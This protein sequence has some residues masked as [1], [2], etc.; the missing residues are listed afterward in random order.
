M[1]MKLLRYPGTGKVLNLHLRTLLI[2][3]LSVKKRHTTVLLGAAKKRTEFR[4][5]LNSFTELCERKG[6]QKAYATIKGCIPDYMRC[7]KQAR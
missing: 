7:R 5:V 1:L 6:G 4:D 3:C 2:Q